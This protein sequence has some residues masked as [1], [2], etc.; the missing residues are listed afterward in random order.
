VAPLRAV[1][2]G[3]PS[4]ARPPRRTGELFVE[5]ATR[6][7]S[8]GGRRVELVNKEFVGTKPEDGLDKPFL[9]P[10]WSRWATDW[11]TRR[12]KRCGLFPGRPSLRAGSRP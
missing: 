2:R 1:P 12:G 6:E 3:R 7:V 10:T 5:P 11:A 8:L 4:A 9:T